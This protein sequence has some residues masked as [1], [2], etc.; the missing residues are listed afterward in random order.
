[1][2][3]DISIRN[4]SLTQDMYFSHLKMHVQ[5]LWTKCCSSS[6]SIW[7]GGYYGGEWIIMNKSPQ[8]LRGSS[9]AVSTPIF[10][11]KYS[12]EWKLLTRSTRFAYFCTAQTS[13]FQSK[14]TNIFRG[15]KNDL[16]VFRFF[17]S[18][19]AFFLRNFDEILSEFRDEFQKM[20]ICVDTTTNYIGDFF[21]KFAYISGKWENCFYYSF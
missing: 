10:A 13:K 20:L 19:F 17:A 21:L 9:S 5:C 3:T 11:S 18:N 12:L 14:I 6:S 2:F 15:W 8:T 4:I 7:A 1:M 16:N